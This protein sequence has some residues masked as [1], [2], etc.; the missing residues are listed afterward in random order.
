MQDST[1]VKSIA[2][3]FRVLNALS[4]NLTTISEIADEAKLSRPTVYRLLKTLNELGVVAKDPVGHKYYLGYSLTKLASKPLTSHQILIYCADE[5]MEYM[6]KLTG[7]T[8]SLDIKWGLERVIIHQLIGTR[9]ISFI[10]KPETNFPICEGAIGKAL[11]SQLPEQEIDII[12][13]NINLEPLT[14]KTITDKQLYREEIAKVKQRKY[15]TSF[16]ETDLDIAAISVPIENYTVPATI[17][18]IGLETRIS[19]HTLDYLEELKK[20]ANEVSEDLLKA[21]QCTTV[22]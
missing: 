1:S 19:P 7:E 12:L 9:N 14:P 15:A 22:R 18:I 21:S 10:N 20:K 11:L 3:A 8:I 6:R 17:S 4:T 2:R 13:D 5:K 16:S